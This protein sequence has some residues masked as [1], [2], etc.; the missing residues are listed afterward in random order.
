MPT[1]FEWLRDEDRQFHCR[2][3]QNNYCLEHF[4]SNVEIVYV[5]DGELDVTINGQKQR[6]RKG[7]AAIAGS[8]DTH[9]YQTP[10]YSDTAF[11]IVP[12]DM[13]PYYVKAVGSK[14]FGSP[15]LPAGPHCA[16]MEHTIGQLQRHDLSCGDMIAM[17]YIHV[18]LGQFISLLELV[19]GPSE[20]SHS[21]IRDIL[22]YLETHY[23]S[24]INITDL[25]NRFG[26]NKFYISKSFNQAVRCSIPEYV[27]MRRA[28]HAARL[29]QTG[30]GSLVDIAAE[31]G[32]SNI[33]AFNRA[34]SAL[35][36]MPPSLY[37]KQHVIL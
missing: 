14:R 36:G 10:S 33:R 8:F 31:S 28:R 6:L 35:Y 32:F 37:R 18:M 20:G 1:S 29:I 9:L 25:S 16:E 11:L 12:L 21:L 5:F 34:F 3:L 23:L 13:A 17:G 7:S 30:G 2:R 15:F 22:F 27:N 26:Y 19:P 4:H 24:P